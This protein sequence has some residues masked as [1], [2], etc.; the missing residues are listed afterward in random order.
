MMRGEGG[1]RK[2]VKQEIH[3]AAWSKTPKLYFQPYIYHISIHRLLMIKYH[4]NQ[5]VTAGKKRKS[6]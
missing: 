3:L 1:S 6:V 4:S 2:L 5:V